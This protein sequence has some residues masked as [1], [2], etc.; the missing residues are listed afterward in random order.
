MFSY[1]AYATTLAYFAGLR[2]RRFLG[3]VGFPT[4]LG[5]GVGFFCLTPKVQL[6]HVLHHTPLLGIPVEM[7]QFLIQTFIETD[8]SCC[9]PRFSLIAT[10]YKIVESQT[11]FMF[12]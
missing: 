3:G 5:L 6:D 9:V 1:N 12:C 8:H 7:P 11:S 10:C 4:T 2:S